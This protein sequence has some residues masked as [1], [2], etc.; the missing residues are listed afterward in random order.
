MSEKLLT[1]LLER[2]L[3]TAKQADQLRE[4]QKESG[5]SI[6]ELLAESAGVSE[7]HILEA[8]VAVFKMPA[9]RLYEQQIP[10]EV[11]QLVRADLLRTHV[12]L[13]FAFDPDE[14]GTLLVAL[15]DPMNMRGRDLVAIASKCR[16][17]PFLATTSDIHV[18]IDRYYGSEEVQEAVDLYTRDSEITTTIEEEIIRE[19]V[20]SSPV[21]MLVNSMVEQAVRQRASDIHVEA[22]VDRVRVRCR[23]DGVLYSTATYSMRLLPA[24]VARI[25]I[26]SGLDISEK[27]KPQDGRFSYT[28]DRREYDVRVSTLPTVYGEKCVL[29]LNQKQALSRNKSTLGL[30]PDDMEK[31]DRIL[32]RPNGIVLVTGPTGSGKSTTLYTALS[33]LN[34]EMVNIITV[35]DPVEANIEGINQVQVNVKADLTFANALRSILRQDPDIIM[36]GEIRDGETA[37]IAV[38]ASI[39]GHLVV[40]TLHTNDTASSVTRLLDMGVESYLIADSTVGIIAQRLVRRLCPNCKRQ[41]PIQEHEADYLGLSAKER[42]QQMLFE[43]VGCQRCNGTGYYGRIG[44]Y[45]IMEITPQLRS[46]IARRAHT[47][48]LREAAIEEGMMTLKQ[49]A[50]RLVLNGTTA[51][52]ELHTISVEDQIQMN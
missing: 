35:E 11:R 33:E 21:V 46:M 22:E 5:K 20:N 3:L 17:R 47:D 7:E 49:S 39:T 10:M 28:V 36:I 32:G 50:R 51:I 37:S 42:V 26:I 6:R 15:N 24:I 38:Q 41:R 43:P 1:Y 16:V 19:D 8:M 40:S 52:T 18:A 23:V 9:V 13:P 14:P 25:K 30:F 31:F 44:V 29:R 12:V 48:S 4:K 34:S 45:E 2:G 27:R